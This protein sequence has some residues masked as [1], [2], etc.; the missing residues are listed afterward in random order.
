MMA[1]ATSPAESEPIVFLREMLREIR[2][3]M[4]SKYGMRRVSIRP[5]G[6]DGSRLSLPVKIAG[7]DRSGHA[8]RYFGKIL[9]TSDVVS[10]RSMQF[11]KNL[12][13]EVNSVAPVFGFTD[14]PEDMVRRQFESLTAIRAAGVPTAKP[15]G[16]HRIRPGMWLLVAEYLEAVPLSDWKE[17]TPDQIDTVFGYLRRLHDRGVF[18]GDIKPENIMLGDRIYLLDAGVLRKDTDASKK[19]AYDLACL[20]CT[21][22]ELRSAEAALRA[23]GRY[24]TRREVRDAVDYIDLVQQRQDFHFTNEQKGALKRLMKEPTAS[25]PSTR[26]PARRA[27]SIGGRA[28]ASE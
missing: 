24:Y 9:R 4:F 10:D 5:V 19:Q 3:I 7:V 13:L 26:R 23:A 2:G 21:F 8:V 25:A 28:S 17:V 20:L 14:T 27:R 1:K 11:A 16:Y 12:Y 18:H 15:L 6:S 22:L